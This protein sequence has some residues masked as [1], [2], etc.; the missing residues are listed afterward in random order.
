MCGI[1]AIF[2]PSP[3]GGSIQCL[4]RRGPDFQ[5]FFKDNGVYLAHTRLAIVHPESGS[6]PIHYKDWVIT[7]NGEIYNAVFSETE[8]DCAWLP[9]LLETHGAE[10]V[11]HL[12]G[13]FSFVAYNK[14]T[15]KIIVGRD[16]IGV[17]P[18][19]VGCKAGMV[20]FSSLLAA[21]SPELSVSHVPPGHVAEFTLG[22]SPSFYKWTPEYTIGQEIEPAVSLLSLMSG[23][24][25]KRL[26]GDVPWGVLLSGGL[27]STIVASLAVKLAS[28]VRPDY[29][30]VHSFCIGLDESPDI[31]WAKEVAKELGTHHTSI[32]YTIEEGLNAI[33]EV[34]RAIETYDVTTVRAS[35]PMWLL[36][37]VLK[38]RGIKMVLSGEGSDELFAG[39]LY[40]LYCPD[41]T[42][43][44]EECQRK[45]NELYAYDCLRAN[46]SLGDWGVE[47]RVPFLSQEVVDFA[48]NILSPRTKLSGTH[49]DGPKPEKWWLREHFR[50]IVPPVVVERTKAQFSDAV[51][52]AWIDALKEYS[53]ANVS[54]EQLLAAGSKWPHN[55][56]TTKEAYWY[57]QIFE[58]TFP[59]SQ[60]AETVLYQATSIACSTS[61]AS[62]WHP[63]FAEEY[64]P[65]GDAIQRIFKEQ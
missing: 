27:D 32:T 33:P 4:K 36:G 31:H 13:I 1:L 3:G 5:G 26:M 8:T 49:P 62:Q 19:Y 22:E 2:G 23:A 7:M 18:L 15:K 57:R 28:Q 14:S 63:S 58:D 60:A 39:Y 64:D 24:V 37:R 10:A 59:C 50:P 51:G 40:N 38:N 25:Q 41:E 9:K 44:A 29:P 6:Q 16:P 47:A 30:T 43:M 12:D 48:M 56:P 46:K 11:K 53:S 21:I 52:S 20:V 45:M 35:T 42:A 34:I 65:S 55:T 17:T 61:V 54:D